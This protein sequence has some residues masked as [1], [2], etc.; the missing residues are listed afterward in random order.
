[1]PLFRL[2]GEGVAQLMRVN[3][4]DAGRLGHPPHHPRH[5][6]TVERPPGVGDKEPRPAVVVVFLPRREQLHQTGVQRHVAV[7][8]KLAE[9]DPKPPL[10]TAVLH[11]VALQLAEFAHAH[12]GAGQQ[13]HHEL[14]PSVL[15]GR[16]RLQEPRRRRVVEG[17]WQGF[18][19]GG[20]V[21]EEHRGTGR[22][23][24][25]PPLDD[26][27]EEAAQAQQPKP[28]GVG[29]KPHVSRRRPVGQLH[30]ERLHVASVHLGEALD[31]G[32][33]VDHVETE[34]TQGGAGGLHAG[35]A[36]LN[37]DSP[38]D[39]RTTFP[40]ARGARCR[41]MKSMTSAVVTSAGSLPTKSKNSFRSE[42]VAR[43]VL[44]RLLAATN[45]ISRSS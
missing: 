43:T 42:A 45:S 9:R 40:S 30:L 28:H 8:V 2:G 20:H 4:A 12:T 24:R 39:R 44:G 5:H 29:F 3:V 31:L 33:F 27:V 32:M 10:A 17:M 35:G 36:Q 25:P 34:L 15:L 1:M 14:A 7:G 38:S 37:P 18:V 41:A 16:G 13:L 19:L 26:P 21:G 6:V 22:R 23:L 11:G